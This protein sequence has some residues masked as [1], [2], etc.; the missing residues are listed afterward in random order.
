M[1]VVS[2]QDSSRGRF[3]EGV[4]LLEWLCGFNMWNP[5]KT[6][7]AFCKRRFFRTRT[8]YNIPGSYP[9]E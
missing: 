7:V 2:P 3:A 5:V 9:R 4:S 1:F 6:V 8:N